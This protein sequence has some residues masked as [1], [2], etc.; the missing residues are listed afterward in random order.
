MKQR[1]IFDHVP[2]DPDVPF[3]DCSEPDNLFLYDLD[4]DPTESINLADS[5]PEDVS[6]LK[7]RLDSYLP[8][9]LSPDLDITNVVRNQ[10]TFMHK[11]YSCKNSLFVSER[12]TLLSCGWRMDDRMVWKFSMKISTYLSNK[13]EQ[14]KK[15]GKTNAIN[16]NLW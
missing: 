13:K 2:K 8:S 6:R 11:K 16:I 15:K 9:M 5:R 1:S 3:S 12:S 4:S 14:K 7:E 10:A